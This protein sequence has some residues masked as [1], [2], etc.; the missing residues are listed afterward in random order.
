[1]LAATALFGSY[2]DA[3]CAVDRFANRHGRRGVQRGMLNAQIVDPS[4]LV[5]LIIGAAVV[6]LFSGLAINAVTRRPAP[7]SSRCVASSASI[8]GIMEGTGKPEYGKVVDICTRDSLRELATPGL[9]AALT[10]DRRRLRSRRRRP[11][12]L[13]GRRHRAPA[14]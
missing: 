11:G 2:T 12:R 14:P 9:L 5:G 7:S 4:T 10:P 3:I 6:F 1:M 13:P 8:P